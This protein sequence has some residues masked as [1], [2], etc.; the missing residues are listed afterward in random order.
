LDFDVLFHAPCL[1]R[2][3][4]QTIW[5]L[6][7]LESCKFIVLKHSDKELVK[8]FLS[9]SH[10]H[11]ESL[12]DQNNL[13]LESCYLSALFQNL[14]S[15]LLRKVSIH[16]SL[17]LRLAKCLHILLRKTFWLHRIDDHFITSS[18][19]EC[20]SWFLLYILSRIKPT[21]STTFWS[22][23][24]GCLISSCSN[25]YCSINYSMNV[26]CISANLH[27]LLTKEKPGN[28]HI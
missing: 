25:C 8:L 3:V 2:W 26:D 13:I 4:P 19:I 12:H 16:L 6:V 22:N 14:N 17:A 24:T 27:N 20:Y 28:V 9:F 15:F 10:K 11:R 7:L 1:L 23:S 18:H 5:S 21:N